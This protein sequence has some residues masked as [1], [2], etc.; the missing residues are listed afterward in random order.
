MM[1]V[2]FRFAQGVDFLANLYH[3]NV[4]VQGGNPMTVTGFMGNHILVALPIDRTDDV[5]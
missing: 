5:L 4:A 3:H 2:G 1:M